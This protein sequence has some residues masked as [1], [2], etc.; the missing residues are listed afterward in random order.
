ME[1]SI[2]LSSHT[3][4]TIVPTAELGEQLNVYSQKNIVIS[5]CG[6]QLESLIINHK[7]G[8]LHSLCFR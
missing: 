4:Q 5:S 1:H 7:K 2:E 8:N 6:F 3:K